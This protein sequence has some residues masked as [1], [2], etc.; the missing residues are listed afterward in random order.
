MLLVFFFLIYWFYSISKWFFYLFKIKLCLNQ[1]SWEVIISTWFYQSQR[2]FF[3]YYLC[4]AARM[5]LLICLYCLFDYIHIVKPRAFKV[6]TSFLLVCD[7]LTVC[8]FLILLK[9]FEIAE[10]VLFFLFFTVFI[11]KLEEQL[12]KYQWT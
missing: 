10:I 7:Y 3:L 11:C 6:D 9:Y 8:F 4:S 2:T 5:S 12:L 1:Q